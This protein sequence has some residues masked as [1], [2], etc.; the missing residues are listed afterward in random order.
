MME[1]IGQLCRVVDV[2]FMIDTSKKS[3]KQTRTAFFNAQK[4]D[5]ELSTIYSPDGED[6]NT[7]NA[8]PDSNSLDANI[9]GG[10]DDLPQLDF[11]HPDNGTSRTWK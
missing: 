11:T 9:P 4:S 3:Q 7:L 5:V 8:S 1:I 6:S 2:N 10:H